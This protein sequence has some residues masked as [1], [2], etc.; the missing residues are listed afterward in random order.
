[1]TPDKYGDAQNDVILG[2]LNYKQGKYQEAERAYMRALQKI[3]EQ[4][5]P[6]QGATR[7]RQLLLYS[8]L[9]SKLAQTLVALGENDRA[10]HFLELAGKA[11]AEAAKLTGKEPATTGVVVP[12]QLIISATKRQL[13]QA[14]GGKMSLEEFR[15][16]AQIEYRTAEP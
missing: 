10:R 1:Q 11:A 15:K 16:A 3:Q 7:L 8:E 6:K 2:D 14:A 12:N 9:G 5:D 13:D 4:K